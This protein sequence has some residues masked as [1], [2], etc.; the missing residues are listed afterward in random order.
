[1]DTTESLD[2]FREHALE[3]MSAVASE[4]ESGSMDMPARNLGPAG[5]PVLNEARQA[6]VA[7][8]QGLAY[9]L[10]DRF[11]QAFDVN[12]SIKPDVQQAGLFALCKAARTYDPEKG[13]WGRYAAPVVFRDM[14]RQVRFLLNPV[15]RQ[16]GTWDDIQAA[17]TGSVIGFSELARKD[18]DGTITYDLP[19]LAGA[20]KRQSEEDWNDLAYIVENG[21]FLTDRERVILQL[22]FGL[23][24]GNPWKDGEIAKRIGVGRARVC[25][26]RKSATVKVQC[27]MAIGT[28]L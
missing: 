4:R 23:E 14:A 24:D 6:L 11:W 7:D 28:R 9:K 13:S 12:V 2:V 1:M 10:A 26:L 21:K 3:V 19:D 22:H 17:G 8:S 16:S 15:G 25:Q 20:K 18:E 27:H 5:L